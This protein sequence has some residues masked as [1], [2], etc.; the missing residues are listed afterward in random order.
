MKTLREIEQWI[1][2][3]AEEL[4]NPSLAC[5]QAFLRYEKDAERYRGTELVFGV[6]GGSVILMFGFSGFP[7][8]IPVSEDGPEQNEFGEAVS[9]G[10]EKIASGLWALTPSLNIPGV[11]HVFVTLYDVPSPAPWAKSL[12]VLAG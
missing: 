4:G 9:F 2:G 7:V 6:N 1:E 12:I 8:E 11:I 5:G 3:A 10:A